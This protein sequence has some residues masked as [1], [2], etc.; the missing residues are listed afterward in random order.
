M[1]LLYLPQSHIMYPLDM[2]PFIQLVPS[3]ALATSWLSSQTN[4]CESRWVYRAIIGTLDAVGIKGHLTD[5]LSL[6]MHD[7]AAPCLIVL[8]HAM[9]SKCDEHT[10]YMLVFGQFSL[11]FGMEVLQEYLNLAAIEFSESC[12]SLCMF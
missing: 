11:K 8:H 7:A 10:I 1:H 6:T 4:P 3:C 2:H 5:Q 12:I 9:V